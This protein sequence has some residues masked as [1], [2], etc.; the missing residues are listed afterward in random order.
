MRLTDR[1]TLAWQLAAS[2]LVSMFVAG[3]V[4]VS[5]ADELETPVQ[6]APVFLQVEAN[7]ETLLVL[8]EKSGTLMRLDLNTGE[9]LREVP[10]G[11][12]P[13]DLALHPDGT[14][15]FISCRRGQEIVEVDVQTFEVRRRLPLLGDPTGLA[16]SGD[17]LRLYAGVHS[18]DQVAVF[19]LE[20]GLEIMRLTA[21]NGPEWI[22]RSP[23]GRVYVTNLLS[24]PVAPDE[25]CRNEITVIDDASSRV[26]ERIILTNANIGRQIAFTADG[27]TAVAVISRPK[28]LVPMVQVARG[29][30]VTNGFVILSPFEEMPPVQLLIDLPNQAY[31]DPYGVV[32]MPDGLKFYI[33]SAGMDM[34]IAVDLERVR[35]VMLKAI[36]GEIPRASDHL[37]LSRQYVAARIPVGANPQAMALSRD[38][39]LLFVAN[40][41]HDSISVIDTSSD[42][43]IRT[44]N[45]GT[46]AEPT[47]VGQGERFFTNAARI[48]QNQFTC[49]SCHPDNGFDGLQYD[50]EPD[51]LGRNILDNRNLRG[52]R[53]TA[54][55][56]WVG[57][58]PDLTT[59]CGTRT[60]KWI[61][62]TGWLRSSEVVSLA[63][64]I[65]SIEPVVNPNVAT[66]GELTSAQRR[67]KVF[68]ERT[69]TNDG[70]PIPEESQ[71]HFC[72][73]GPDFTNY[74]AFDVGTKAAG[75]S[76]AEFDTAHLTNIFESAP[77]LH[78]GRAATLEEIW[79]I[80]NPGDRHGIS[81]DWTKRQLNDL[82]EYL[83]S[84]GAAEGSRR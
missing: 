67:G 38:G 65:R 11:Q 28:N 1:Y 24:N 31:A 63:E 61:V 12:S 26:I 84:L 69:R 5:F 44:M 59:Q 81:S 54:P 41:L 50:L 62:R 53:D 46:F 8:N 27:S 15:C 66:D 60:A 72:H 25:S 37:G 9:I 14:H 78:D 21:G 22:R 70:V 2:L 68:F 19:D 39:S 16:V 55:F 33:S 17:G 79:T 4:S 20:T 42:I 35:D 10:V 57:S 3:V 7:G 51:G 49:T 76:K 80:H 34:V 13:F 43:V 64:Y 23:D 6:R 30:V 36:S 18:L 77:F 71:C 32:M 56:K 48:F 75:D 82:V 40:R 29:W 45:F 52:V 47:P 83:K 58:N 73:S 74:R